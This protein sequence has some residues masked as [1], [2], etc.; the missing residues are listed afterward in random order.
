MTAT[1]APQTV[2]AFPCQNWLAAALPVLFSR[3]AAETPRGRAQLWPHGPGGKSALRSVALEI[4]ISP[5]KG[6]SSSRTRKS[7][8]HPMNEHQCTDPVGQFVPMKRHAALLVM[9]CPLTELP[10]ANRA[11]LAQRCS[12]EATLNHCFGLRPIRNMAIAAAW[13]SAAIEN[14]TGSAPFAVP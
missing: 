7:L 11:R 12:F 4:P 9:D 13:I 14:K 5:V 3:G 6:L 8:R 10:H 1:S 2:L